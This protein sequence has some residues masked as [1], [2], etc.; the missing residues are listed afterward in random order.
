MLTLSGFITSDP[1]YSHNCIFIHNL[2]S[3]TCV[4]GENSNLRFGR[5]SPRSSTDFPVSLLQ[6]QNNMN[7]NS[8]DNVNIKIEDFLGAGLYLMD[9]NVSL[10]ADPGFVKG[11]HRASGD[12]KRVW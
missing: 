9:L 10:V 7:T 11:G 4:R 6:K 8:L 5:Q 3:R 1:Y 2:Y 12:M